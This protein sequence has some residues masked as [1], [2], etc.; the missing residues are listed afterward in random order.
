MK[1][2]YKI[3][4]GIFC[5]FALV[6]CTKSF[7]TNA[8][9]AN[10]MTNYIQ[11]EVEDEGNTI[12]RQ[13][14]II[15]D[16]EESGVIIP[17]EKYLEY[18]ENKIYEYAVTDSSVKYS[19]FGGKTLGEYTIS[20]LKTVVGDDGI[21]DE[22]V[23]FSKTTY[24]SCIRF[25]GHEEGD[26]DVSSTL[27]YNYDKWT[28]EIKNATY[29]D[30]E[31]TIGN[32]QIGEFT[33]TF[34]LDDL[35]SDYFVS[36]FK[37]QIN[38]QLSSSTTC[39]TP[40]T[41]VYNSTILEGK[42]WGKAFSFGLI[43]GLIE[44]PIAWMID[45][46]YNL[47]SGGAVA[48]IFS[49]LI[50]TIIVRLFLFLVTFKSTLSQARMQEM[51]PE[52]QALQAKYPNSNTNDMQKQQLAQEQMALYKKYKVNPFSMLLV[53]IIQFPIFIAVWGAMSG[54][55]VLR[56]PTL[57]ANGGSLFALSLSATT[58]SEIYSGNITAIILFLIM[59]AV[60]IL[61]VILPSFLQ[62]R[63]AKKNATVLGKNPAQEQNNKQAK[64]MSYF[65]IIMIIFMGFSLPVAMVIYWIISA[66]I[67][68]AQS[69]I[70]R[71]ISKNKMKK[72]GYAKYKTKK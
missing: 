35:P 10:I 45:S 72:K 25:A 28:E 26:D 8:D 53:L 23:T 42:S 7:C 6:G 70:I 21:H 62:K 5:F 67:A 55:A 29:T 66:L 17:S 41:G 51:Q 71:A 44:Y 39:I 47:F 11:E 30:Q 56:L 38:N 22:E 68:L 34:T 64:F 52:L 9:K 33:Y 61:S 19:T 16:L 20:E 40:S 57:F 2:R 50:V 36:A 12:T 1:K 60:Q 13:E 18:L 4:A 63:D 65:M 27:W 59:S 14:K 58:S 49:I 46:F 32:S 69:L 31:L 15:F 24:Y 48:A 43:E 54:S 37:T 3:L